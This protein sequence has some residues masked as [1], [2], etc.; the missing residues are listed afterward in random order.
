MLLSRPMARLGFTG[1]SDNVGSMKTTVLIR[2]VGYDKIKTAT[3][4]GMLELG[5]TVNNEVLELQK[6]N[7]KL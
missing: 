2:S 6:S 5:S 1:Y 4:F 3:Q 7:I